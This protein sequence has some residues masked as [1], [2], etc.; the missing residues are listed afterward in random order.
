MCQKKETEKEKTNQSQRHQFT[1]N[2]H[3]GSLA[4]MFE[5]KRRGADRQRHMQTDRP[6]DTLTNRQT[7]STTGRDVNNADKDK[8]TDSR[9]M[10]SLCMHVGSNS[11]N[12]K[13]YF[14]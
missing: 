8:K 11:Q 5:S 10:K 4:F 3:L 9:E 2:Y 13:I 14:I 7:G 6:T 1:A 12:A